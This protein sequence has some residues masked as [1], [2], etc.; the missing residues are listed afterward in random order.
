MVP[1]GLIASGGECMPSGQGL[2]RRRLI[3][4]CAHTVR[5]QVVWR[6]VCI[7]VGLD[8]QCG[9][10]YARRS[11]GVGERA[12]MRNIFGQSAALW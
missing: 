5:L 7:L 1:G 3:S 9:R 11:C 2:C 10:T 12:R 4:I 6:L 8:A